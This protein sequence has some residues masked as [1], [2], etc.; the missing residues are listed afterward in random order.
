MFYRNIWWC[1]GLKIEIEIWEVYLFGE[2]VNEKYILVF[3]YKLVFIIFCC[4][5]LKGFFGGV[6]FV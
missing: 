1:C 2:G 3:G 4:K 6:V 5:F